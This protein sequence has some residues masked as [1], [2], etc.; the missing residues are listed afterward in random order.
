MNIIGGSAQKVDRLKCLRCKLVI[1]E[2]LFRKVKAHNSNRQSPM[3][4]NLELIFMGG[5][6]LF[7]AQVIGRAA[8]T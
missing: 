7:C 3:D 2:L 5:I 8:K 4:F 6:W 1:K